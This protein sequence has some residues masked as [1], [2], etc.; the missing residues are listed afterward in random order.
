MKQ[1][2]ITGSRR[3]A[4]N[5]V[6]SVKNINE[7]ISLPPPVDGENQALYDRVINPAAYSGTERFFSIPSNMNN[8]STVLKQYLQN[9]CGQNVCVAFWGHTGGKFEKCGT[10][11]DVGGDYISI[12]EH[13][14][15][16]LIITNMDK[17]KYI[18]VFCV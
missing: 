5:S 2:Y 8:E 13:K 1:N 4:R 3:A 9:F 10:L 18:S 16:R 11:Q 6:F 7:E 12:K 14:S 15:K 17:I